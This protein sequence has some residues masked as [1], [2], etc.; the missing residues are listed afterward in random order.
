MYVLGVDQPLERCS[1]KVLAVIRRQ[2]DVEDKIVVAASG[3]WDR[4]SI[5]EATAFQEQW[6]DSQVELPGDPNEGTT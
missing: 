5:E 6:F 1:A 4:A 3:G 2:D